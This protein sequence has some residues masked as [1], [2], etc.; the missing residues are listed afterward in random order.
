M[1]IKETIRIIF[2]DKARSNEM[3][4]AVDLTKQIGDVSH[5][6]VRDTLHDMWRAGEI[7]GLDYTR[8]LE[9]M[10]VKDEH[11]NPLEAYVYHPRTVSASS[12]TNRD[13][14]LD[15]NTSGPDDAQYAP[16]PSTRPAQSNTSASVKS[17]YLSRHTRSDRAIEIPGALV[18]KLQKQAGDSI[19]GYF[20]NGEIII[21]GQNTTGSTRFKIYKTGETRVPRRLVEKHFPNNT[22][23]SVRIVGAELRIS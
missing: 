2:K 15:P 9:R 14:T 4:T 1:D 16:P 13:Q 10:N 17:R 20:Q 3:F 12:Y 19:Y 18:S 8:S 6:H 11:G 5:R 7:T 21:T 22:N 23:F